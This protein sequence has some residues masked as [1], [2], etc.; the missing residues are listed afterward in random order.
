ME[1]Q[2]K[3]IAK[4]IGILFMSRDYAHMAHL[5]T[6]SYAKHMAL[7]E[8]YTG[9]VDLADSLAEGAQ[10]KFGLLD[11]ELMSMKGDVMDPIAA[12]ESHVT[13][14]DNMQKKCEVPFLDN[15]LQEIQALYYTTLYK[16]KELD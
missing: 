14:I 5:K 15:I 12:L 1:A 2:R 11:I 9:V 4:T 8:F 13:M 6:P 3:L 7:N 16:L 10:G